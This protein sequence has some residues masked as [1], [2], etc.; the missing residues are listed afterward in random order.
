DRVASRTVPFGH[1]MV[2]QDLRLNA[3]SRHVVPFAIEVPW[4]TP[5]NTLKGRRLAGVS[6]GVYTGMRMGG[7]FTESD[8]DPL[9]AGPLPIQEQVLKALERLRFVPGATDLE[10]I[11]LPPAQTWFLQRLKYGP[12][13]EY[14]KHFRQLKVAFVTDPQAVNVQLSTDDGRSHQLIVAHEQIDVFNAD[15]ALAMQLAAITGSR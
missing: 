10:D 14:A 2:G 12:S 7:T 1:T 3:G 11:R 15:E 9:E 6:L 4:I 5:I 8:S 13:E